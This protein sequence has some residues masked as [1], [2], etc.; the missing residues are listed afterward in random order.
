MNWLEDCN[1]SMAR[2]HS[3][4]GV[5]LFNTCCKTYLWATTTPLQWLY[6]CLCLWDVGEIAGWLAAAKGYDAIWAS[7]VKCRV[8]VVN[9]LLIIL[10]FIFPRL[11]NQKSHLIS[12]IVRY[13]NR[14][15]PP[16]TTPLFRLSPWT[17]T[18]RSCR[19]TKVRP[20]R[21]LSHNWISRSI[22]CTRRIV[23]IQRR[24][25]IRWLIVRFLLFP[26]I[27]H[28]VSI[29]SI[30]TVFIIIIIRR[31][32]LII[33]KFLL[34]LRTDGTIFKTTWATW[35]SRWLR[36]WWQRWRCL[37]I[38]TRALVVIVSIC[39][40]LGVVAMHCRRRCSVFGFVAV[41]L[42]LVV[43]VVHSGHVGEVK[44]AWWHWALI[45]RFIE[46]SIARGRRGKHKKLAVTVVVNYWF[47]LLR[48]GVGKK[49]EEKNMIIRWLVSD[50]T[51]YF[52]HRRNQSN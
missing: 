48:V 7:T 31:R 11:N 5:V 29:I 24:H 22:P 10:L 23:I 38:F 28:W 18:P 17:A 13:I 2:V 43:G 12:W 50:R 6:R 3:A 42:H 51:K 14:M 37:F 44:I 41:T 52:M 36:R 15:S 16:S 34:M 39:G 30:R 32:R 49:K 27:H 1:R 33:F 25:P 40:R 21:R 4:Y 45:A 9:C 20:S 35:W 46:F 19:I 8:R 47:F 26:I